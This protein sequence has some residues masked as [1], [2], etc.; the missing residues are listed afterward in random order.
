MASTDSEKPGGYCLEKGNRSAHHGSLFLVKGVLSA[1]QGSKVRKWPLSHLIT[2]LRGHGKGGHP[3]G[4]GDQV[5]T[6]ATV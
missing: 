3:R 4:G 2:K 6:Q 5:T 1:L